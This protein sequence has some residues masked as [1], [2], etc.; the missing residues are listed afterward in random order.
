VV[1]A[2]DT[3][4]DAEGCFAHGFAIQTRSKVPDLARHH[5]RHGVATLVAT[6]A[7][8]GGERV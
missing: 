6:P 3:C 7:T 1:N 5:M 8:F 4:T 2:R